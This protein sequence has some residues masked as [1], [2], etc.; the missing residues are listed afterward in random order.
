M[1]R[2]YLIPEGDRAPRPE[3]AP[4][5]R[6]DRFVRK[7]SPRFPLI[8]WG[9]RVRLTRVRPFCHPGVGCLGSRTFTHEH[10]AA[11][12]ERTGRKSAFGLRPQP[13]ARRNTPVAARSWTD[14]R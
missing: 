11:R 13:C 1:P 12:K 7:L 14:R 3:R 5:G 2:G 9:L 4:A 6:E 8:A 10:G